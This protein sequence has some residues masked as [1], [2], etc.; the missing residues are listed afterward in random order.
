MSHPSYSVVT[1]V[2]Q[3]LPTTKLA[4]YKSCLVD[5]RLKRGGRIN[6]AHAR[7]LWYAIDHVHAGYKRGVGRPEVNYMAA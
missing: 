1:T 3:L 2:A 4:Y 5:A 7:D 6:I